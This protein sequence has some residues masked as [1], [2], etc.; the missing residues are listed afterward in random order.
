MEFE[1]VIEGKNIQKGFKNFTLNI[2]ELKIPKGFATAL[3]GENGAGKT[4]LLN[5]LAGIRIDNKGTLKYFDAFDQND[6]ENNPEVKERI[7]YTGTENYFLPHWT[8]D[9]V[10]QLSKLLYK[11]FDEEKYKAY[12]DELAI[13]ANGSYEGKKKISELSDG[14]KTKLTLA[15][16]L[17]RETDLL[18][19]DEPASPLDPLMRD[20]LCEIIRTYISS[21]EGRSVF[22]S[23]HNISDMENVT[24]YAIIMEHGAI[25]EQGFVEDLKEK[26]ILVKGEASDAN[27][28]RNILYTIS[29]GKYGFEGICLSS[30]LDKLAGM[31]ITTETASLFQISVAV[32]KKNTRIR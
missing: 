4:T 6:R 21:K 8:V 27:A 30:D 26:Y 31:D 25:V 2:P 12:Y 11:N 23:T 18:I 20:K 14:T 5:I 16:I 7:G 3:I 29:E 9:Q 1:S 24:D 15:A 10:R 17:S 22:F 19:M 13:S 32:M 28:A